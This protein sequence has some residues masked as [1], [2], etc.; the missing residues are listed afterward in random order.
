MDSVGSLRQVAPQ[1]EAIV[2]H[3]SVVIF[4]KDVD[5]VLRAVCEYL[6]SKCS[7]TRWQSSIV[8]VVVRQLVLPKQLVCRGFEMTARFHLYCSMYCAPFD[9]PQEAYCHPG[10]LLLLQKTQCQQ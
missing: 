3:F 1:M 10:F 4:F 9:G 6:S 7:K 5:V 2:T 8:N